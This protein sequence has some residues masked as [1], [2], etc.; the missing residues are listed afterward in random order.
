MESTEKKL[1]KIITM[2]DAI[3]EKQQEQDEQSAEL[4]EAVADL[5]LPGSGYSVYQSEEE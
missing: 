5:G 1:D 4:R 2:L 3:I